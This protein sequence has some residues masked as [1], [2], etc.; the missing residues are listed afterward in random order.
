MNVIEAHTDQ[1]IGLSM[2][3]H[4]LKRKVKKIP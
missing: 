3:A 4:S 2:E 1:I